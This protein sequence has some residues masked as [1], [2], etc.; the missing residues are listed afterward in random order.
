MKKEVTGRGKG[1]SIK[2]N[3]KTGQMG[4]VADRKREG[5]GERAGQGRRKEPT[6][7]VQQ[8]KGRGQS[9]RWSLGA[10]L[11]Q[12][13]LQL[14]VLA[15]APILPVLLPGISFCKRTQV[16]SREVLRAEESPSC[17]CRLQT[18]SAGLRV[19]LF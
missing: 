9:L 2:Y 6:V 14:P 18:W 7:E 16:L 15:L 8:A 12:P 17:P 13:A 11:V 3:A 5:C 19:T 4:K 1:R 10:M